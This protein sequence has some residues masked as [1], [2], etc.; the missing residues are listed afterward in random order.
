MITRACVLVC[1]F[2]RNWFYLSGFGW[3]LGTGTEGSRTHT[4]RRW[5]TYLCFVNGYPISDG[6]ESERRCNTSWRYLDDSEKPR[7]RAAGNVD[8]QQPCRTLKP[9]VIS[10]VVVYAGVCVARA[11][12]HTPNGAKQLLLRA[13]H[14]RDCGIWEGT[15]SFPCFPLL[16]VA[17]TCGNE[18]QQQQQRERRPANRHK[19]TNAAPERDQTRSENRLAW[20]EIAVRA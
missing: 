14:R 11:N 5:P 17:R 13:P 7:N 10:T 15:I 20:R 12:F 3:Q 6:H 1:Y 18:L 8:T 19:Q 2:H 9:V 4:L 16:M